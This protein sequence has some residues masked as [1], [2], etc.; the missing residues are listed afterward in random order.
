VW[1]LD[2]LETSDLTALLARTGAREAMKG[3]VR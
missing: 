3:A 2:E 1:A